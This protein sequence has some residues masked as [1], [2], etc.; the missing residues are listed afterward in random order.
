MSSRE[1]SVYQKCSGKPCLSLTEEKI[2]NAA[3]SSLLVLEQHWSAS[4]WQDVHASHVSRLVGLGFGSCM[5][6]SWFESS[7]AM[8]PTFCTQFRPRKLMAAVALLTNFLQ[9]AGSKLG[10]L[11]QDMLL[12][13]FPETVHFDGRH[14]AE[15]S[16]L[17]LYMSLP[18][19]AIRRDLFVAGCGR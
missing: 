15:H 14:N 11:M 4:A 17:P 18:F 1:G 5:H 16:I 3:A 8:I 7:Y 2:L 10:L 12:D 19:I 13:T 9:E 6:C